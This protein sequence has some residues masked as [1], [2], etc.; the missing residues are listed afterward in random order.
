MNRKISF[1]SFLLFIIP[2]IT[3]FICFQIISYYY[4]NFH[5]FPFIDGKASVSQIGR[6]EKTI[7]TFKSGFFLYILFS[8]IFYY[9]ISNFFLLIGKRNKLKIYGLIANFFLLIYILSLGIDGSFN[10]IARRIAITLYIVS[11]YASHIYVIKILKILKFEKKIV[12]KKIYLYVFYT[13]IILMSLL[14]IIGTP[15]VNPLFKY[16]NVLK[17]IIEWNFF[18]LTIIFYIPTSLLFYFSFIKKN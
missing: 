14:I 4:P 16:P 10:A 6:G 17:N 3:I 2:V 8:I 5:T 12:F 9:K 1:L 18:L 7:I 15:W 11:I 13:I